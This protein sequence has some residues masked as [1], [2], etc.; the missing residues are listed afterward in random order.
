MG[1]DIAADVSDGPVASS[2]AAEAANDVNS[3]PAASSRAKANV[4]ASS[5]RCSITLVAA[6]LTAQAVCWWAC[7]ARQSQQ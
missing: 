1:Q 4:R 5:L 2:S 7:A 3:I 6:P